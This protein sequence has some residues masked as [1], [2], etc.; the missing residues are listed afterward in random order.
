MNSSK[1]QDYRRKICTMLIICPLPKRSGDFQFCMLPFLRLI[2]CGVVA[3]IVHLMNCHIV[4]LM[5]CSFNI[6]HGRKLYQVEN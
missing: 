6:V 5:D 2:I 4:N 1:L 3:W